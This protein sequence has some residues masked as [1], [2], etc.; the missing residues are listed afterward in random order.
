MKLEAGQIEAISVAE[1][2]VPIYKITD[3]RITNEQ[4]SDAA[5]H[6]F[7][8]VFLFQFDY[9][10]FHQLHEV[11]GQF[12]VLKRSMPDV[13]I[14]FVQQ[15]VDHHFGFSETVNNVKFFDVISNIGYGIMDPDT[16]GLNTHKYF[17][18]LVD[19]YKVDAISEGVYNLKEGNYNFSEVYFFFEGAIPLFS[20]RPNGIL[21]HNTDLLQKHGHTPYWQNTDYMQIYLDKGHRYYSWH[22]PAMELYRDRVNSRI[23]LNNDYPKKI[24]ISRKDVKA[25]YESLVAGQPDPTFFKSR[26]YDESVFLEP[27]FEEKGYTIVT[28]QGMPLLEQLTYIKNANKI[29][30]LVGSSFCNIVACQPKA[31]TYEIHIWPDYYIDYTYLAKIAGATN[32]RVQL[33]NCNNDPGEMRRR[34]DESGV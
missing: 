10:L 33:Q 1:L 21:S 26:L 22:T 11:A 14:M 4:S 34:L 30:G 9:Y 15:Q 24:Y 19:L 29:A 13:K 2:D 20:E 32:V 17:E 12:E 27:Y 18:G 5:D 8:K 28:F 3:L 6:V 31:V 25:R 23:E 16:A 7:Q